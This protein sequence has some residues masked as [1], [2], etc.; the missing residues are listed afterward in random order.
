VT[1]DM[2]N[3]KSK[4]FVDRLKWVIVDEDGKVVNNNPNK[5]DL[6]VVSLFVENNGRNGR[7]GDSKYT[8]KELLDYLIQFYEKYGRP[9]TQ[10]DFTNNPGYP[11]FMTYIKRFKSWSNALK[12]VELDV[13]SMVKKGVLSNNVQKGRLGEI[14]VRDHFEKNSIDLAGENQ[15]SPCDG[16]C[17]NGKI[18]DVKSSK[19]YNWENRKYFIFKINNKHKNEIE[20]Y[21]FLGFSENYTEL[22]YAYRVSTNDIWDSIGNNHIRIGISSDY[23]FNVEN[24]KKDITC[25]IRDILDRY[26]YFEKIKSYRKAKEKGLTIYE[27]DKQ[28]YDGCIIAE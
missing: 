28:L 12:L 10:N 19:F 1:K 3:Y 20:I 13:D 27:Y 25:Q 8:D 5:D 6:K 9:P 15:N 24:M 16:I 22:M 14:I 2:V 7:I 11:S 21:Y 23:R 18:Y 26:G 17:P 4:R